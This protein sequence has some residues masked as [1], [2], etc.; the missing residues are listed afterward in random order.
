MLAAMYM[1]LKPTSTSTTSW[2]Q[3]PYSS[4]P[5][6]R[7]GD[8]GGGGDG[9]PLAPPI[10]EKKIVAP[11]SPP[12]PAGEPGSTG[13]T[14][15]MVTNEGEVVQEEKKKK[16]KKKLTSSLFEFSGQDIP[17]GGPVSGGKESKD[18][19]KDKG[20]DKDKNK[21]K[22]GDS[23]SKSK[24]KDKNK[25]KGKGKDK[26]KDKGKEKP[27]DMS[28]DKSKTPSQPDTPPPPVEPAPPAPKPVVVP[29]T[30]PQHPWNENNKIVVDESAFAEEDDPPEI[31]PDS[32]I[33]NPVNKNVIPPGGDGMRQSGSGSGKTPSYS[34]LLYTSP[35]PRDGLLSR[36]PSS[37]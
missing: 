15:S 5:E 1:L 31:D 26:G 37:A 12:Q 34:C 6:P 28:K 14:G 16:K 10:A 19:D 33:S 25:D 2:S 11:P 32:P 21:D 35:S 20:K 22:G 17:I 36:M 18:K 8:S 7:N 13:N 30:E 9:A 24:P 4:V 23:G 29:D 3:K 27:K